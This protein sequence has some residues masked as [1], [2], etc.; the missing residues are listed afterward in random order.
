ME[1]LRR[2]PLLFP[3]D[4]GRAQRAQLQPIRRTVAAPA[5]RGGFRGSFAAAPPPAR[6][7]QV[8]ITMLLRSL[9][10]RCW[11]R[12]SPLT[13]SPNRSPLRGRQLFNGD[14]LM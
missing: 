8:T 12:A 3:R 13:I 11:A 9:T 10:L 1:V 5:G 6:Q 14:T 2:W 4:H 7:G